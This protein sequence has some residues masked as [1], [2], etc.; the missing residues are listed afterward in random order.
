M[1]LTNLIAI[2]TV[3]ASCRG[4]ETADRPAAET[5]RSMSGMVMRSDS[6]IPKMRAH[7]DSVSATS[8]SWMAA[9]NAMASDMLD[10]MGSDMA[11]MGMKADS[12]WMALSDSVKL[13]LADLPALSGPALQQR[14]KAHVERMRRLVSAH[15]AMMRS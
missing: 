11:M 10:A 7:L 6:L 3:A 2:V 14:L 8:A 9:H 15:E 13:D 5:T 4:K 1:R 12:T